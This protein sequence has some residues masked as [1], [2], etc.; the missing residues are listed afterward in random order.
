MLNHDKP[1][2]TL[3]AQLQ[4]A[5]LDAWMRFERLS[6]LPGPWSIEATDEDDWVYFPEDALIGLAS[7]AAQSAAARMAVVGCQSCW[8]PSYW[9]SMP[10]QAH[11]LVGGTVQ[12]TPWSAMQNEPHRH[13]P[14]LWHAAVASQRLIRQMAQM[15]FCAQHHTLVQSLATWF[16]VC[17]HQAA[18]PELDLRWPDLMRWRDVPQAQLL[19]A[20]STLEA[21]GALQWSGSDQGVVRIQAVPELSLMACSCHVPVTTPRP[22][23]ASSLAQN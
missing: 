4:Q 8:M 18:R 19:Q 7:P 12:R 14:W 6:V 13:A 21:R 1:Q 15:A 9:K 16:L 10:L 22:A 2:P 20:L 17:L 5:P 11:V 3:L 23:T